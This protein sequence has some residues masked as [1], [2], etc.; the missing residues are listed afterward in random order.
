[1][2]DRVYYCKRWPNRDQFCNRLTTKLHG[3]YFRPTQTAFFGRNT[4]VPGYARKIEA[5]SREELHQP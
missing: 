1:L 5:D 4:Q 3:S 2:R